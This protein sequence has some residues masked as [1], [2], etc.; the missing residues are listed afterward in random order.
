MFNF[1]KKIVL[2]LFIV[3]SFSSYSNAYDRFAKAVII[4]SIGCGKTALFNLLSGKTQF[5]NLE[6]D[7]HLIGK[8]H[9]FTVERM[10]SSSSSLDFFRNLK[11]KS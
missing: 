11:I 6:H 5:K 1:V 4:G 8:S 3:L 7:K 2:S 10:N 9:T